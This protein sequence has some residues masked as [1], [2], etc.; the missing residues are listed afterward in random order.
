VAAPLA[1]WL[2]ILASA[3]LTD[4]R[5]DAGHVFAASFG[6]LPLELIVAALVYVLAGRLRA[7]TILGIVCASVSLSFFAQL[8]HAVL[9]VPDWVLSLSI[10]HQYGSPI[11]DGWQWRPFVT[12]LGEAFVLLTFSLVQFTRSDVE[13]GA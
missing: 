9:N 11:T 12:L 3:R 13:R 6:I 7:A 1:I 5:V 8:L 2:S 4:L 10:S